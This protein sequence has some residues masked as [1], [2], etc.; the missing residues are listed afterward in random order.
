M[1]ELTDTQLERYARHV[2]LDEV[3]EEGQLR[4]LNSS[5][6]VVGAGG[7]GSP[8][9]QYLAAAGVGRIGIVDDDNVDISNL[10][11][12]TIHRLEDVGR[13]KAE[14][15]ADFVR[16]LNPEIKAEIHAKRLTEANA[17]AL[18]GSY[19]LVADGTDN[20]RTRYLLNDMCVQM[21]R[22]LVSAALLR[23]DGQLGVFKPHAG[24]DYPCYRCIF[25][26][27]PPADL[28]SRC[29][30]A[31]IFGAVAGILGSLQATEVLKELLGLGDTMAGRLMLYDGLSA[32]IRMVTVKRR[33]DCPT[34]GAI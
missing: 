2:V 20:F 15:A 23:F 13:P 28:I 4:L 21:K 5:V 24:P 33:M 34:C 3:G 9:I 8:L 32:T 31:G 11:R 22:T 18:I 14:S 19:D 30:T 29:E 12:Q 6:L 10:Q 1:P 25:P 27:E 16:R 26:E 7:L 17:A